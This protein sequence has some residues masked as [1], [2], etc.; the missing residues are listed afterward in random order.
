[1]VLILVFS[2]RLS[3]AL[4]LTAVEGENKGCAVINDRAIE[5]ARNLGAL[6]ELKM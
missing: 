5:F 1:M 2:S 3:L 4:C 6:K